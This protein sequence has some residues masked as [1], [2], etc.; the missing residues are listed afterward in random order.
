MH[1]LKIIMLSAERFS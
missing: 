1:A